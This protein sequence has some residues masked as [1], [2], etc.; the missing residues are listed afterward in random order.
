M[1][2][3]M[4]PSRSKKDGDI[5]RTGRFVVPNGVA[6][7]LKGNLK[8]S[9]GWSYCSPIVLVV[10]YLSR[11]RSLTIGS[12]TKS[13]WLEFHFARSILQAL[14]IAMTESFS[15]RPHKNMML[16]LQQKFYVTL[17]SEASCELV[18]TSLMRCFK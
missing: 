14:R 1:I 10:A 17:R 16:P 18:D 15:I 6:L 12:L 7:R 13:C 8:L 11:F 5:E 2:G 4:S 9:S 3:K